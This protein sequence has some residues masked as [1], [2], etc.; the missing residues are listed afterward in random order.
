MAMTLSPT[1]I[2]ATAGFVPPKTVNLVPNL[3][4]ALIIAPSPSPQCA[5]G[6]TYYAISMNG[7]AIVTFLEL[8]PYK[9]PILT[10]IKK[11]IDAGLKEFMFG[12]STSSSF[13][14][15]VFLFSKH[16][17]STHRMPAHLFVS[18][19]GTLELPGLDHRFYDLYGTATQF[20][21]L[22]SS[23]SSIID[24]LMD[25]TQGKMEMN[26]MLATFETGLKLTGTFTIKLSGLTKK[27]MK[28]ITLDLGQA[29]L[30]SAA[31]NEHS[32]QSSPSHPSLGTGVYFALDTAVLSNMVVVVDAHL[33][34]FR[35]ILKKMGLPKPPSIKANTDN[36]KFGIFLQ[37]SS[38]GLGIS[39]PGFDM[40]CS[41]S[42]LT[43]RNP[44]VKSVS[45]MWRSLQMRLDS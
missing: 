18:M 43:G 32:Q 30:F 44:K 23:A 25:S 9:G 16:G 17:F 42:D 10:L 27:M 15:D 34:M 6:L 21:N 19:G 14:I 37:P 11:A 36:A 4:S 22:G 12:F 7:V 35:E 38:M 41:V 24:A 31:T 5:S 20:V 1:L 40:D 28:D 2:Q 29:A 33:Q 3:C 26:Q 39:V 13:D 45:P 8:A